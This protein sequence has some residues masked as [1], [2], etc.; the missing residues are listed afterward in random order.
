[1]KFMGTISTIQISLTLSR[2][3]LSIRNSRVTNSNSQIEIF[4]SQNFQIKSTMLHSMLLRLSFSEELQIRGNL[5]PSS[6]TPLKNIVINHQNLYCGYQIISP[7]RL[8]SSLNI[9]FGGKH[10]VGTPLI[11]TFFFSWKE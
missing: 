6:E 10:K 11:W 5:E 1:M 7:K 3:L 9:G 8:L 4:K 2:D